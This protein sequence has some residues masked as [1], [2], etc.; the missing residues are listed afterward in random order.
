MVSQI[1]K[2]PKCGNAFELSEGIINIV[3]DDLKNE[4]ES[5]FKKKYEEENKSNISDLQDQLNSK[6]QQVDDL[7]KNELILLRKQRELEEREKDVAL[8]IEKGIHQEKEKIEESVQKRIF[9]QYHLKDLE[10]DKTIDDFEKK[11]KEL[12]QKIDQGSQQLKGEVAELDI[13]DALR[14][15]F[16]F[17]EIEPVEKGKRGGDVTQRIIDGGKDCG[18]IIWEIK[19][20]KNWSDGWILKLKEDQRSI[21]AD[22]AVIISAVL[23]KGVESFDCIDGVWVTGFPAAMGIALI[24]RSKLVEMNT[25]KMS[26]EGKDK[27]VNMLYD[28]LCGNEFKHR[29]S[30]LME[31]FTDMKS[32]L[33]REKVAMLRLWASREKQIEKFVTHMSGMYGDIKG[34]MGKRLPEIE[35]LE[36]PLLSDG[37][38]KENI[39]F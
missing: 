16:P 20:T 3:R 23:P 34:I 9:E 27:K 26:N 15:Q 4:L 21:K 10:K 6:S 37:E 39:P 13:E 35:S 38:D 28:Y 25:L 36:L 1:V 11:V 30:G 2:C 8:E 33:D 12:Q 7:K 19:N 32:E 31:S 18:C 22:G 17:D 5:E 14:S 24:L 29:V